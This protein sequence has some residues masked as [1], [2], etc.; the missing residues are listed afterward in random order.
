MHQPMQLLLA[1]WMYLPWQEANKAA[2]AA[3]GA[4]Q[5][6]SQA[7]LD[8]RQAEQIQVRGQPAWCTVHQAASNNHSMKGP[9]SVVD[10]TS[11]CGL[12][13][14]L[15][16]VAG[17]QCDCP[18]TC[19]QPLCP[20]HTLLLVLCAVQV[21]YLRGVVSGRLGDKVM[22]RVS[23]IIRHVPPGSTHPDC[24]FPQRAGSH[25]SQVRGQGCCPGT[26]ATA[27]TCWQLQATSVCL[28]VSICIVQSFV[29][30]VTCLCLPVTTAHCCVTAV[31]LPCLSAGW[32]GQSCAG[33]C[34][35]AGPPAVPGHCPG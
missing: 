5:G 9:V 10:K 35:P 8:T 19:C 13:A 33:V 17:G 6:G 32:G 20:D 2:A 14:E 27:L 16:S 18:V 23:S 15:A 12:L 1:E 25:L 28:E 26:G 34:A 30:C 29:E 11:T 31:G 24:V 22:T 21:D 7:A 3:R 4:S